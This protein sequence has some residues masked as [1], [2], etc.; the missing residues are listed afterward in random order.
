MGSDL[1]CF[2]GFWLGHPMDPGT[3]NQDWGKR[4]RDRFCGKSDKSGHSGKKKK[5]FFLESS[6]ITPDSK[7]QSVL[8][9]NCLIRK[10][11]L[12][13]TSFS[14]FKCNLLQ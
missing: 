11:H 2:L 13:K 3:I 12:S 14:E 9:I 5:L 7:L 6:R 1:G 8:Q 10:F 4:L